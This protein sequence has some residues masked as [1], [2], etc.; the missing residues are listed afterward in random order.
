MA[1][2]RNALPASRPWPQVPG[3]HR[4]YHL[5]GAS[6]CIFSP[7]IYYVQNWLHSS[8]GQWKLKMWP[9]VQKAHTKHATK[10][11]DIQSF[12]LSS[13]VSL[14]LSRYVSFATK[15]LAPLG[16]RVLVR[17]ADLTGDW[18][19]HSVTWCTHGPMAAGFCLLPAT[20]LTC[21][22]FCGQEW[23]S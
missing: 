7:P 15:C 6:G 8:W 10:G 14:G 5:S 21:M 18:G 16:S 13:T 22:P 23:R 19:A 1:V 3:H 11:L 12:F 2:R 20:R 9:P 4:G 17:S